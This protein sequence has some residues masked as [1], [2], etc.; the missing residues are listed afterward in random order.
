MIDA[1]N[2][3]EDVRS[4]LPKPAPI[5]VNQESVFPELVLIVIRRKFPAK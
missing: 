1:I 5:R 3:S 4:H 2:L